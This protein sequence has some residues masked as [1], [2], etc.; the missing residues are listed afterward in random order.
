MAE[1]GARSWWAA[2]RM[3]RDLRASSCASR[4]L[5]AANSAWRSRRRSTNWVVKN[6]L[7]TSVT[8]NMPRWP[9]MKRRFRYCGS[10][11]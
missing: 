1:S 10:L 8:A 6:A 2:T 4:L 3:K 11:M 7:T 9:K 5:V